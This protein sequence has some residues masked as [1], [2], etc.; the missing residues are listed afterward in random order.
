MRKMRVTVEKVF[1]G[2]RHETPTVIESASYK[3]DYRL[4]SKKE[5]KDYCQ[6]L[7][8]MTHE[9]KIIPSEMDLP[10]LLRELLI[11]EGK[12]NL[13]M[14]TKVRDDKKNNT[15]RVAKEGETPTQELTIGLK[16]P[17]SPRLFE[18]LNL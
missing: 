18:G 7:G 2:L 12:T 4:L 15:F 3:T 8:N 14:I 16:N 11:K 1:R 6:V 9:K 17:T 13:K 10:P 5:E